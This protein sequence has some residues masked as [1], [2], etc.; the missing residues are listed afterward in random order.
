MNF[1]DLSIIRFFNSFAQR[2]SGF[3]HLVV[4]IS[5][6]TLVRG[7]FMVAL[8]LW[9]WNRYRDEYSEQREFLLFG[10][11]AS[12]SAIFVAR[13]LALALPFRA[14][15]L[16]NPL[17]GFR[18]PIGMDPDALL[19]WSAF[20]SD[21]AAL[22]FCLAACLWM[23]SK[24]LG[25]IAFC[26]SIF[27]ISLPRI[28]LGIHHPT[29]IIG[30]AVIGIGVACL[31]RIVWLRKRVTRPVLQWST[32]NP[33]FFNALMFLLSFEIAE[34]FESVRHIGLAGYHSVQVILQTLK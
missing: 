26:Y 17:L 9:A 20:P 19:G 24:R 23:V 12:V 2:S 30:G 34:L 25:T 21:H 6:N 13:A 10:L 33:P 16:D 5:H 29:D 11:L 31:S 1:F 32:A 27:V 15:P 18:L 28:Y 22:F 8:F 3:D 4:Q 14:R 7:G